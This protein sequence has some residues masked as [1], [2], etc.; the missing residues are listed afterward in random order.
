MH[1]QPEASV[2][3]IASR[4]LW[5]PGAAERVAAFMAAV[6]A[7]TGRAAKVLEFGSGGSTIFLLSEGARVFT[8][9]HHEKWA[10]ELQAKADQLGYGDRLQILRRDRPYA[11]A[12]QE[13]AEDM[14]FDVVLVDGRERMACFQ[15]ALPRLG[16]EGLMLVD[17]SQRTRYWPAFRALADRDATTFRSASRYTTLWDLSQPA[18]SDVFA[19]KIFEDYAHDE[20][21]G[22][23]PQRLMVPKNQKGAATFGVNYIQ[24]EEITQLDPLEQRLQDFGM[25]PKQAVYV[26]P[27]VYQLTQADVY[28]RPPRKYLRHDGVVHVQTR[29]CFEVDEAAPELPE[30]VDLPGLT[31]DL[32]T[33]GAGRYSFFLLDALPKLLVAR[34]AGFDLKAFDTILVNTGAPW[35]RA[36]LKEVLGDVT[37]QVRFFNPQ[38]PGFRL[39]RSVHPER[40]RWSRYTPSWIQTYLDEVF[41]PR[42]AGGA[43]FGKYVYISRQRAKG[44]RILNHPEFKALLDGFGFTEVY[45]EDHNPKD[46]AAALQEAEIMISPHG[47][48]LANLVFCKPTARVIELFSSHYT[49]QYFNLARDRG[50]PYEPFL[51]ADEEGLSVFDR[52]AGGPGSRALYN[53][54]DIVVPIDALKARLAALIG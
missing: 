29:T 51:C 41:Q 22:I 34:E 11:S 7:K 17:D 49:P 28:N 53:R 2:V 27:Q 47:A 4:P 9:E 40:M 39:E 15:A 13:F 52:Y 30:P 44:R 37:A 25:L 31:L 14:V 1:Q 43:S 23:Q 18:K 3:K 16:A 50:Q 10:A 36:T 45:A 54:A 26:V 5:A 21:G 24:Q 19:E 48:G 33:P 38:N 12:T 32:T 46:L 20:A 42:D 6:T 35:L 8:V